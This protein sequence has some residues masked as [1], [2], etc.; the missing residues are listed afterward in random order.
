MLYVTE[1]EEVKEN[2]QLQFLYC[3][4]LFPIEN[5]AVEVICIGFVRARRKHHVRPHSSA[6]SSF[7]EGPWLNFGVYPF[8]LLYLPVAD[9]LLRYAHSSTYI[10]IYKCCR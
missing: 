1:K 2:I 5:T 10:N 4:S 8:H 7:G 3:I 6:F 9:R